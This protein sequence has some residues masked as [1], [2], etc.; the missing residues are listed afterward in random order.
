MDELTETRDLLSRRHFLGSASTGVG[1]A[2]LASL[3]PTRD[4]GAA[5]PSAKKGNSAAHFPATA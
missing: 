3:L 1:M 4:V 5:L 2:A